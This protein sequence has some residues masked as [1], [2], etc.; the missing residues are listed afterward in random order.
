L[1]R[2]GTGRDEESEREGVGGRGGVKVAYS[3]LSKCIL[4]K[5]KKGFSDARGISNN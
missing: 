5:T 2:G 3:L 4:G 1:N